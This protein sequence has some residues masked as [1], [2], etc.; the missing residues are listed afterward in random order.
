MQLVLDLF[1]IAT[2][3]QNIKRTNQLQNKNENAMNTPYVMRDLSKNV[4]PNIMNFDAVVRGS[5]TNK[6]LELAVFTIGLSAYI[7]SLVLAA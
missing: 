3:I 6:V 7:A 4:V 1:S 5:R 2:K